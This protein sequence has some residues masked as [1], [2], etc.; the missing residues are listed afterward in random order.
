MRERGLSDPPPEGGGTRG[1]GRFAATCS[2]FVELSTIGA[3]ARC[4]I[5]LGPNG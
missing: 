4:C 2:T 3:K 5:H 1:D